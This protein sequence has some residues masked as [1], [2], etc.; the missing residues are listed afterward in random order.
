MW[1]WGNG[2]LTDLVLTS[3]AEAIVF[4][5]TSTTESTVYLPFIAR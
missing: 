3:P 1:R 2:R 4:E 5:I